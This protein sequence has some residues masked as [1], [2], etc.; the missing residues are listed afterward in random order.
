MKQF[1]RFLFVLF[2]LFVI[3]PLVELTLLLIL[4]SMT[5]WTVSLALV[6]V[7]GLAGSFLLHRQG[8]KTFYKIRDDMLAG[9]MPTDSLLD[10]MLM[11]TAGALLLTPGMVTDVV[12][13]LLLI[14]PSRNLIKSWIVRW[15]KAKFAVTVALGS[16]VETAAAT[17][18]GKVVDSYTVES[19]EVESD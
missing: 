18:A 4:G 5:H 6:I 3:L 13:M 9:R 16:Q 1:S 2:L 14:P 10:G 8:I 15:F 11:L 12:A 19:E 17:A 7:T